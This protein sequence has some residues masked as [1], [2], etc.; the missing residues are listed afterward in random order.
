M[1]PQRR[2]G[3]VERL[4][5]AVLES[6]TALTFHLAAA[7]EFLREGPVWRLAPAAAPTGGDL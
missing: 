6:E 1:S 2:D 7:V 5:T 4:S 3:E